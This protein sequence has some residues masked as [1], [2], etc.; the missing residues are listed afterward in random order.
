VSSAV[1]TNDD[2]VRPLCNVVSLV[3]YSW[4][5]PKTEHLKT[6]GSVQGIQKKLSFFPRIF[7]PCLPLEGRLVLHQLSLVCLVH[8]VITAS[9]LFF[10]PCM[11]CCC[12]C[13]IKRHCRLGPSW[14]VSIQK[15][16]FCWWLWLKDP[17]KL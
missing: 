7:K 2:K 12:F 17:C 1:F 4:F 3:A 15:V 16:R 6:H 10:W 8:A 9:I 11:H 14:P 5:N 13:L